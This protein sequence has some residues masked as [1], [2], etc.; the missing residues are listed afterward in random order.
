MFES[1]YRV[2]SVGIAAENKALNSHTLPVVPIEMFPLMNGEVMESLDEV[3][4]SGMDQREVE[5]TITIKSSSTLTCDWMPHGSNRVTSPDVRRGERLLI[6]QYADSDKYYW[7]PLGMD[8]DL[9]R[10]ETVIHAWS[11]TPDIDAELSLTENM[12][13]LEVS[14]HGKQITLHT[15]QADGEPFEYTLQLNTADGIFFITDQDGN[16]VQLDSANRVLKSVNSDKTEVTIDKTNL[17]A[18][19][20][21]KIRARSDDLME[22]SAGGDVTMFIEGNLNQYVKGDWNVQ[23]DGGMNVVVAGAAGSYA[24]GG[25]TLMSDGPIALDGA[26]V[27]MMSGLAPAISLG[28]IQDGTDRDAGGQSPPPPKAATSLPTEYGVKATE[29]LRTEAGRYAAMDEEGD[30]G[31]TPT[32]YPEDVKPAGFTGSPKTVSSR[33][34]I[35]RATGD[36]PQTTE[37]GGSVDYKTQLGETDFT[38]GDLSKNALFSHDVKEQGGLTVQEIVWNMEAL[39]V[40]VLQ[41][42][43]DQVGDYRINSGFRQGSG[44]SQHTKGMAIDI[45]NPSWSSETYMEVAEWI[46]D[47]LPVDQL[48]FEHGNSVWLHISFDSTKD[49]Q[50]GQLLTMLNGK[51]ESGLKNYYA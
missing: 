39:A 44:K 7:T 30:I 10:L 2:V 43:K 14:T 33:T 8:D 19:A 41:P 40:N 20:K 31:D 29:T 51:Y 6:W 25:H 3:E 1:K 5:Y 15:T 22:I 49:V 18:Y 47:N 13:S 24:I 21:D 28:A 12:Y 11:A 34:S 48:I 4:V 32:Y 26:G 45:Q 46:A 38:I 27:D 16:S 42:L 35:E 50:R 23:V 9:R 37:V 17:F 36:L